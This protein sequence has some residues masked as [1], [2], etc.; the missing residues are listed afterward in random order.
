MSDDVTCLHC[1]NILVREAGV[2]WANASDG[3][4]GCALRASGL[5]HVPDNHQVPS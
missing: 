2:G 3:S 4:I 5:T 1:G